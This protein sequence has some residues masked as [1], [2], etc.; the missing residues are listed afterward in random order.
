MVPPGVSISDMT[1]PDPDDQLEAISDPHRRLLIELLRRQTGRT[2]SLEEL[3][4]CLGHADT[5]DD[6]TTNDLVH[7]L[8]HVHLPKLE[9]VG[10]V[11]VDHDRDLIRYHPSERVERVLDALPRGDVTIEP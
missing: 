3:S 5:V 7:R 11:D 10:L 8:Y 2:W 1:R 6:G 9:A 4:A